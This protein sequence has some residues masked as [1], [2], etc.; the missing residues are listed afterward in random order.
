MR[1]HDPSAVRTETELR[2]LMIHLLAKWIGKLDR[3]KVR[4]HLPR[5]RGLMRLIPAMPFHLEDEL[6]L[7][8]SGCTIFQFPEETCTIEAG[9]ICLVSRGLPH[10]EKVR[11][12]KGPFFNLVIC[13]SADHVRCHL[14]REEAKGQ[15]AIVISTKL[16]TLHSHHLADLLKNAADW[17]R[18]GDVP[19][20]C[21]IKGSLLANLS[22]L[23]ATLEREP[24]GSHE[25]LKVT[26]VRQLIIHHL[27]DPRLSVSWIG[28]SLHSS[29][30]YLSRLFREA[31]G[32]SM[33]AY[34][35]E[36]RTSLARNLLV[37]SALNISE[38]SHASGY[39][40]PSYFTRVFRKETG[41]APRQYR[42]YTLR[43]SEKVPSPA[44]AFRKLR[45]AAPASLKSSRG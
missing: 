22:I 40:D 21:A 39:D 24:T 19:H 17:F 33:V 14:A 10:R 5:R 35:T 8:I 25:P 41:L 20:R 6:F 26:Q 23:L 36:R 9:E 2:H 28:R 15:P 18:E 7:Q 1:F 42:D 31:T 4:L 43:H 11:A 13:Y 29:P 44:R 30:D 32:Q 12:R 34:I 37:S 3:D 27:A 38:I 16:Q 45:G